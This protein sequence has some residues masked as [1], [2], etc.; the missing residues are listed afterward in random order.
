ME[1]GEI[2]A[3]EGMLLD[4]DIMQFVGSLR[5]VAPGLPGGEKVEAEAEAGLDDDEA[6]PMLPA[7]GQAVAGKEDMARLQ[8]PAALGMIDIVILRRIGRA[9]LSEGELGRDDHF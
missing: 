5:I 6:L 2:L 9:I 3:R 4:R 7:T 8:Q 1:R